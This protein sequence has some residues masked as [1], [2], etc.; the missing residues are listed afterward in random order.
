MPYARNMA[1]H[2]LV[3]DLLPPVARL[4]FLGYLNGPAAGEASE[5]SQ[6]GGLSLSMVQKALLLGVGLQHRSVDALAVEL[7]LPVSQVLRPT[8][9]QDTRG[10]RAGPSPPPPPAHTSLW[11]DAFV[12]RVGID[13]R[14]AAVYSECG[15]QMSRAFEP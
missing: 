9:A 12:F 14:A 5:G 15:R 11:S 1:D 2:Y 10:H 7:K 13:A 6:E 4:F 3:T 8:A